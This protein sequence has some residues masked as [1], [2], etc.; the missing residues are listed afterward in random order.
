VLQASA[1]DGATSGFDGRGACAVSI[2]VLAQGSGF[3]IFWQ[4]FSSNTFLATQGSERIQVKKKD[5]RF[6]KNW[7]KSCV[8]GN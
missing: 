8:L 2:G 1:A 7:R 6:K 3:E 5:I 4:H